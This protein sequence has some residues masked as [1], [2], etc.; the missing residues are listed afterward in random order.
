MLLNSHLI[1]KKFDNRDD[2]VNWLI[3][4]QFVKN[5]IKRF[6][7]YHNINFENCCAVMLEEEII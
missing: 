4:P 2:V 1:L 5:K 7:E 6:K 3:E